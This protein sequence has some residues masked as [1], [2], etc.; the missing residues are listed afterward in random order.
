MNTQEKLS[1][2]FD[3]SY[4]QNEVLIG[5]TL[6]LIS[7]LTVEN[8]GYYNVT[9]FLRNGEAI[10]TATQKQFDAF[11]ETDCTIDQI[12][13]TVPKFMDVTELQI[14]EVVAERQP[15]RR[16]VRENTT[17]EDKKKNAKTEAENLLEENKTDILSAVK[18]FF[19]S[20]KKEAVDLE[21]LIQ[22]APVFKFN[23][24][25][26]DGSSVEIEIPGG[27][28]SKSY[29][30]GNIVVSMSTVNVYSDVLNGEGTSTT[31]VFQYQDK[32]FQ[33]LFFK[34]SI[35][36]MTIG[37]SLGFNF[38]AIVPTL[39]KVPITIEENGKAVLPKNEKSEFEM[40]FNFAQQKFKQQMELR[41][42]FFTLNDPV[43]MIST[44]LKTG[45]RLIHNVQQEKKN[46]EAKKEA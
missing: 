40:D 39:P 16:T 25:N 41:K 35:K 46:I 33:E 19:A 26:A 4:S 5:G 44:N 7:R 10:Y 45:E 23:K 22:P 2:Y 8:E 38:S 1:D 17:E 15:Q 28:T 6:F 14:S 31:F 37:L 9:T 13:S 18:D 12:E 43:M 29:I 3:G 20:E 32:R 21:N 34:Q 30:N 42:D 24:K 11:L 27:I 36:S